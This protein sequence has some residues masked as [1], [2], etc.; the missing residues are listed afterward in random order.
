M[1]YHALEKALTEKLPE[2]RNNLAHGSSMLFAGAYQTLETCCDIIN[3]L[4]SDS[5]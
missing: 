5:H 3:Q 4:F 2:W 1:N